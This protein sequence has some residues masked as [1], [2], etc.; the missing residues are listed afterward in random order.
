MTP[1]TSLS[2]SSS[3]LQQRQ[4]VPDLSDPLVRELVVVA[5]KYIKQQDAVLQRYGYQY[6]GPF[7][8]EIRSMVSRI[9]EGQPCH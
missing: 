1:S 5:G 6:D 8:R 3:P 2:L 7:Q 4:S 9:G